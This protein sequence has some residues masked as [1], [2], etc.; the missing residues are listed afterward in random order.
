MNTFVKS[1]ALGGAFAFAV[2]LSAGA[3]DMGPAT[4]Y[5]TQGQSAGVAPGTYN[6]Q[7]GPRANSGVAIA[8]ASQLP[9]SWNPSAATAPYSTQGVGPKT[10]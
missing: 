8:P 4:A 3:A 1:I 9:G 10:N 2:S 7:P 6:P 5:P